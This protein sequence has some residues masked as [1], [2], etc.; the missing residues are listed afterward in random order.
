MTR[1]GLKEFVSILLPRLLVA[2]MGLAFIG[3]S[4][5]A[6]LRDLRVD[7]YARAAARIEGGERFADATLVRLAQGADKDLLD[8]SCDNRTL[9]TAVTLDLVALDAVI[10]SND[11]S[12][13]DQRRAAAA[14][15]TVA[16]VRCN[17]MD[18]NLW[19]RAAMVEASANGRSERLIG[20]VRASYWTA[21]N[22]AWV[23]KNRLAFVGR[24]IG[25]G[26]DELRPDFAIDVRKLLTRGHIDDAAAAY[27][28][29]S[30]AV[31]PLYDA[32]LGAMNVGQVGGQRRSRLVEAIEAARGP[33]GAPAPKPF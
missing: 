6:I 29:A 10:T 15:A 14:R 22:E 31:L 12:L 32:A 7:P 11:L 20:M 27:A 16:A 30:P 18:G 25:A 19:L 17:P 4:A 9:R 24:L 23:I 3:W 2:V 5:I 28:A 13:L 8:G 33:A 21:P 26:I 1:E